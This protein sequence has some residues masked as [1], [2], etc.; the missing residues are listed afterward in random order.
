MAGGTG[1]AFVW[2]TGRCQFR[3]ERAR[4]EGYVKAVSLRKRTTSRDMVAMSSCV[5]GVAP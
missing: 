1:G 4:R 2:R 3:I 5:P